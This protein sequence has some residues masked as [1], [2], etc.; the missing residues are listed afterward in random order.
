MNLMDILNKKKERWSP[1]QFVKPIEKHLLELEQKFESKNLKRIQESI[2]YYS[3]LIRADGEI[4][5]RNHGLDG[6]QHVYRL[7]LDAS[8]VAARNLSTIWDGVGDWSD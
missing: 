6:M 2:S 4:L 8:G 7:I 3:R 1:D 5:H